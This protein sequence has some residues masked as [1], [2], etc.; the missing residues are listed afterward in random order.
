M[1]G[2]DA[3]FTSLPWSYAAIKTVGAIYLLYIAYSMWRGAHVSVAAG[4]KPASHAFR[5]GVAINALNPKT[6]LFAAAVLAVIFPSNLSLGESF[7]IVANHLQSGTFSSR[8]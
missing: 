1:L 3:S 8:R 4:T 6:V 5:Q 2:L 7:A